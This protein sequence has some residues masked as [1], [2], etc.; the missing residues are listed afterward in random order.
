MKHSSTERSV[1]TVGASQRSLLESARM[2][3]VEIVLE[4]DAW[5]QAAPGRAFE[6]S[7][8]NI[9]SVWRI[10]LTERG[11]VVASGEGKNWEDALA[12]ALVR[13]PRDPST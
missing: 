12:V 5:I 6:V 10:A 11:Q 13:R 1:R 4:R 8:N 2:R 9:C 7:V 3:R